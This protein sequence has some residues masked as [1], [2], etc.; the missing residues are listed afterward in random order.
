MSE[1]LFPMLILPL[2]FI[3]VLIIIFTINKKKVAEL[4]AQNKEKVAELE[5]QM[6][7][8]VQIE[9][10]KWREKELDV[11][12]VNERS[13]AIREAQTALNQWL[14]ENEAT[15][16]RDA[17]ERSRAVIAGRVAEHL[18]PYMPVFPYNPKDA[19]WIGSPVDLIVFDGA[20]EGI[21]RNVIFLEI[22]TGSASLS[23][24]QRQL[25]DAIEAG[26][27]SWRVLRVE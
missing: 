25:R 18:V 7:S 27:V 26:K 9:C 20:D 4:D 13:L 21:I 1:L 8:R 5:A 16:R 19:H 22:K 3:V 15:I 11:V 24:R 17:I 12:R 14:V 2:L 10:Q 23:S 6:H